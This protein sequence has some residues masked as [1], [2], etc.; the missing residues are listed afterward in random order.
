MEVSHSVVSQF[1]ANKLTQFFVQDGKKIEIPGPTIDG[2]PASSNITPEYCTA[3]VTAFG[4]RDRFT[5]VGGFDQLNEVWSMPVVLVMSIWD[6]HYS[7]MLWLD[8]SYP[9]EKAGQPGGDRGDC[10]QD[11]GVPSDVEASI[12]DAYVYPLLPSVRNPI[13]NRL[14]AR[15]SG[16]TSV[17]DPLAPPSPSKRSSKRQGLSSR[18]YSTTYVYISTLRIR[19]FPRVSSRENKTDHVVAENPT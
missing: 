1:E 15:S 2:F 10:A 17:S 18:I 11:S 3:E 14:A 7:N 19:L 9:P 12:P 6:D 4:D 8:S 16:P 5:E 13:A